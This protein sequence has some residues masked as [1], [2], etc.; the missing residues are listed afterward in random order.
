MTPPPSNENDP[1]E[2]ASPV[3]YAAG[4]DPDYI[5][6]RFDEPD[7]RLKRVYDPAEEGDGQRILVDRLWPRGVRKDDAR[8]DMWL[9]EV[10]PTPTLR[11]WFGHDP[12]RWEE[13]SQRY[14]AEFAEGPDVLAPLMAAARSGRVTLLFAA[15][16]REHN[17]AVVLREVLLEKLAEARDQT[18]R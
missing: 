5:W 8:I 7:I 11:K 1:K 6:A 12:S 10:A 14:R 9:R 2:P 17:H 3:C 15:R 13:F 16:A 4:A 18:P